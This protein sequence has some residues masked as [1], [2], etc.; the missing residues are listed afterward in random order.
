MSCIERLK[1]N[2]IRH[3]IRNRGHRQKVFTEKQKQRPLTSFKN[4]IN[5]SEIERNIGK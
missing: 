4:K 1:S 3:T 2:N 5:S